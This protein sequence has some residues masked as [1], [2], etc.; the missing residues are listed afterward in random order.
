MKTKHIISTAIVVVLLIVLGIFIHNYRMQKQQLLIEQ[1]Y[2]QVIARRDTIMMRRHNREK[3][4]LIFLYKDSLRTERIKTLNN[5]LNTLR[6]AT[7]DKI[8]AL[9]LAPNAYKDSI[10]TKEFSTQES[11]PF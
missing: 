4:E 2:N 5:N 11:A 10:W 1:Q 9:R 3:E 6:N 8:N 7:K